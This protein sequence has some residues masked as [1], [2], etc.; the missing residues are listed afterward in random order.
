[1]LETFEAPVALLFFECWNTQKLV[2]RLSWVIGFELFRI[3]VFVLN[4][5][6]TALWLI[7]V[8]VLEVVPASTSA[9]LL[10]H[11]LSDLLFRV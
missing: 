3:V 10:F 4:V 2:Y 7:I 8:F 6:I 1:M 5:D 11:N 9:R